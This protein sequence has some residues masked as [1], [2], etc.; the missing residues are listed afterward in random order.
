[1]I[2][3]AYAIPIITCLLLHFEFGYKGPG[4]A[5]F[6]IIILGEAIVGLLHWLGYSLHT[7]KTEYLGSM[8]RDINHE[9]SWTELVEVRETKTDS[10]GNSYTVTR[11]EERYHEEKYYFHTT[12]GTKFNTSYG[13]Y[14]EV[15]DLWKLPS[16]VLRWSGSHIKGGVRFG[17]SYEM[18]DFDYE[19]RE[20]P[21]NWVPITESHS[22][23]NKV[24]SSNS[25]FKFEKISDKEASEMGLLKYPAIYSHDAPCVLSNDISVSPDVDEMFRKFNAKFAP[26][27]QMRLYIL[28][29][30]AKRGVGISEQ[31]RAYWQGGNKNE[32]V[33]CIGMK[34][35]GTVEWARAFSWA[36]EQSKEVETTQWLM[37]NPTLDW[38]EFYEWLKWNLMDWE[39]KEFKDFDYISITLPL[40]QIITIYILSIAENAF[41]IHCALSY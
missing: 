11:I 21:K 17:T 20:N 25:I 36:D 32:F 24:Q 28:L 33:V 3:F 41:A 13:F 38:E 35:N 2:A 16:N 18:A 4:I 9:D 40:W 14:S 30:D 31:Q 34:P 8:V 39:R 19:Q 26:E 5:Y 23:T 10:K 37:H 29:F 22:Y 7:S 12:L 15:R 1:M 6:W 27:F